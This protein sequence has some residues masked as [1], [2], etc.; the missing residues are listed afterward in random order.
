MLASGTL[1]PDGREGGINDQS[2]ITYTE[3]GPLKS[4]DG[5]GISLAS[6][7]LLVMMAGA[8]GSQFS[9]PCPG[10][11]SWFVKLNWSAGQLDVKP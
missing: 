3:V 9:S 8:P 6:D 11:V 7:I 5:L 10:P 4:V 2:P 1:A